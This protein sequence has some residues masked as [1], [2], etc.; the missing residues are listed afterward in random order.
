MDS[1]I[2]IPANMA[3]GRS[4]ARDLTSEMALQ[5]SA[6]EEQEQEKEEKQQKQAWQIYKI[7]WKTYIMLPMPQ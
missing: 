7:H 2:A 5:E 1:T 6:E 4:K 3:R